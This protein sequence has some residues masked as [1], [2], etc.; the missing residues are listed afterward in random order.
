MKLKHRLPA[1]SILDHLCL[2]NALLEELTACVHELNDEFKTLLEVNKGFCGLNHE[3]TKSAYDNF[4]QVSLT[5]STVVSKDISMDECEVT[6]KTLHVNGHRNKQALA[7]DKNSVLNES[8][9]TEKTDTYKKYAHIFDKVLSKFKGS[10]TRIRLVRLSAGTNIIPHIDYDPSYAVRI[11]IPII[12]DSECV[13][14]FWVKNKVE[15]VSLEPGNAYFL[16]TGYKH[17][18]MNF[19]KHDRY[20]FMISIN[21]TEDI[22]HLLT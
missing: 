7:L 15:S 3:F 11:I 16:N 8:T 6:N 21:G 4:F 1:Y 2:D 22:Q 12:A 10:P 14:L 18:V 5:D 17:A 19:S 20:T 9:Y 13:N